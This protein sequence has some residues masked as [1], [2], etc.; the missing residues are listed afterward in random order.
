MRASS[1]DNRDGTGKLVAAQLLAEGLHAFGAIDSPRVKEIPWEIE[2]GK[3]LPGIME[4]MAFV[5]VPEAASS[6]ADLTVVRQYVES[7]IQRPRSVVILAGE[8][9][10]VRRLLRPSAALDRTFRNSFSFQ[11]YGPVELVT[12]FARHC[13]RE[14]I[15]LS[16]DTVRALLLA[17][18]LYSDRKDRRFAN[19]QGVGVLFEASQRRYLERCS[20]ANRFDLLMEPRDLDIPQDKALRT[21]LDRSPAFVTFCPSCSKENPWLPGLP[22]RTVCLHCEATYS[23]NWGVWKDSATYR[24]TRETLTHTVESGA[25]AR[26]ANQAAVVQPRE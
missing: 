25:V 10:L 26:R 23:A 9:D 20:L 2:G 6:A 15:S 11:G 12:L 19:T 5:R 14:H 1:V 18:H 21:A 8:R 17:F 24:R 13:E 22:P 4:G 3:N 7:L 16:P